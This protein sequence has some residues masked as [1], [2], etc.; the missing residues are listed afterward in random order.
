[1]QVQANNLSRAMTN[2]HQT[3]NR[4]KPVNLFKGV[5]ALAKGVAKGV[6]EAVTTL[7]DTKRVFREPSVPLYGGDT[8][9]NHGRIRQIH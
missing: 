7:P 6:G 4:P 5:D 1:M 2:V 8:E 3:P 9:V